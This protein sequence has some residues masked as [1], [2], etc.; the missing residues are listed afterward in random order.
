VRSG[1]ITSNF[2]WSE[3]SV[4]G[5]FPDLI[6]PVPQALVP[7]AEALAKTVLQPI[8]DTIARPITITSWY[9]PLRLNSALKGSSTSQHLK[10][11]AA[12]WRTTNLRGAW[13]SIIEM[14]RAG[15]LPAAGQLIYYPDDRFIH[16][17]LSSPRF[18]LP[19]LCVQWPRKG[20]RYAR[21][22]PTPM[23]FELL[24]PERDDPNVTGSRA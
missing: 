23:S 15:T 20:F 10:A 14:V 3:T 24:V 19:T 2:A 12:D 5:T 13:L 11:E 1:S 18:R 7:R 6:E 22:A 21:H 4:S 9:R 8:R 16:V 17:A